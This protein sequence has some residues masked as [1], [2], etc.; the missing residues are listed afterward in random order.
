MWFPHVTLCPSPDKAS[1]GLYPPIF[2]SF[3]ERPFLLPVNIGPTLVPP[4]PSAYV[5]YE[6]WPTWSTLQK[7]LTVSFAP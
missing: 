2:D 7:D 3:R 4:R 6:K 1:I 5:S